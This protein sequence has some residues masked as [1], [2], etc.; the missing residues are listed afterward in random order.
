[1]LLLFIYEYN[2]FKLLQAKNIDCF[3]YQLLVTSPDGEPLSNENITIEAKSKGKTLFS[4][5][6]I[7]KNGR[8]DFEIKDIPHQTEYIS[9]EV[10]IQ[11]RIQKFVRE[12]P[13]C[14]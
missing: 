3:F 14:K 12:R 9:I 2:I 10:S 11:E 5:H 4:K 13:N 7:V 1:M 6:V 8:V